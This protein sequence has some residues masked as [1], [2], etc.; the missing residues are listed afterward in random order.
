MAPKRRKWSPVER[1]VFWTALFVL[2]LGNM[3][4]AGASS[5]AIAAFLG[6]FGLLVATP[7]LIAKRRGK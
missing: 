6:V 5:L 7:I 3:I 4:L 1:W 2:G